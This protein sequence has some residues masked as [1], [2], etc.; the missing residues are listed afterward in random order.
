VTDLNV[1]TLPDPEAAAYG[2]EVI[3][4][5][6]RAGVK[7][8]WY[9]AA[10]PYFAIPG[11]GSSGL[12]L[13]ES[14][15]RKVGVPLMEAF[16]KAGQSMAWLTPE[17]PTDQDRPGVISLSSIPSPALFIALKQPAFVAFPG[18]LKTPALEA[19]RPAWDP[20]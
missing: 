4:G 3:E 2:F 8:A 7:V 17:R 6:Q 9:P 12:T 20:K 16:L 19:H 15:I 10:S 18:Y 5:L 13:Y 1:F 11:I 14:P